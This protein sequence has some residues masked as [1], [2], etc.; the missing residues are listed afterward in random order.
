[1]GV[2]R[3]WSLNPIWLLLRFESG[4]DYT[5]SDVEEDSILLKLVTARNR[6][7]T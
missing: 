3:H 5:S 6:R 7:T 2:M 4:P 1:V